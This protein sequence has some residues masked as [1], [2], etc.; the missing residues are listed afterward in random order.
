[1]LDIDT[2]MGNTEMMDILEHSLEPRMKSKA[3][4]SFIITIRS[5]VISIR[6]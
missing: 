3:I 5:K 2:D 1:M 6:L 4:K